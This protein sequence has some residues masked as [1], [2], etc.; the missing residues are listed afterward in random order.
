MKHRLKRLGSAL[1]AL[2]LV[3]PFVPVPGFAASSFETMRPGE[4]LFEGGENGLPRQ[5]VSETAYSLAPGVTEYVTYTN[6]PKGDNQNIDYFCEIDLSQ[7]EIMAGYAGM[8]NI[9]TNHEISWRMQTVSDQVES[10]QSFFRRSE[11]YADATIV[12]ALNADFYNMATGEP[13]GAL[14]IDGVTYHSVNSRYYFGITKD[15]KAVISNSNDTSNLAYA[16]GGSSLLIDNG[17][18]NVNPGGRN[19][20][21][22]AIGIKA[23]GTVV[24]MVCYGQRYPVSCGYTPYEVAQM[25]LARGCV[26]ALQL[27]GS[28]SSTFVSRREGDNGIITRN[29]PSDGQERQ[30]SSSLFI[31]SRVKAD[32]IFDHAALSPANEVY[33]PGSTVQLT[34]AGADQSGAPAPL[35]NDVTWSVDGNYGTIDSATGLFHSNGTEGDVTVYLNS[36]GQ[37]VGETTITIAAPDQLLFSAEQVNIG[38]G[39]TSDLGLLVRYQGRSVNYKDGD[40]IWSLSNDAMGS[41]TGNLFKAS[42]TESLTGTATVTSQW[43]AAVT[44]T[45]NLEVGR[46][47]IIAMDFENPDWKVVHG[48]TKDGLGDVVGVFDETGAYTTDASAVAAAT[49]GADAYCLS[50]TDRNVGQPQVGNAEIVNIADGAPVH[51]GSHSM[52]LDYNFTQNNNQTDG[53]CFGLSDTLVLDG[54]PNK[55][56]LWVYVPEGTPN[57]WLRLRYIDGTGNASQIDFTKGTT[58]GEDELHKL[59]DNAWHYYEADL[60]NLTPP[61]TI[62]AGMCIRLMVLSPQTSNTGWTLADGTKIDKSECYGSL[63]FDDLTFVYGSTNRDVVAPK[64]TEVTVNEEP[65]T[66]GQHFG[67]NVLAFNAYFEDSEADSLFNSGINYNNVLLYVDGK[68]ITDAFIDESAGY[69]RHDNLVL[70]Q[71][72]HTIRLLVTDEAGN[73][74]IR[75]YT[76]VVDA[77]SAPQSPVEV[78]C[79]EDS[80][81]LGKTVTLHFTPT[82]SDVTSIDVTLYINRAYRDAFQLTAG[83]G[84][85]KSK[86]AVYDSITN[87]V[88]FTISRAGAEAG[89]AASLTFSIPSGVVPGTM[90]TARVTK[91]IVT[92]AS[93]HDELPTFGSAPIEIPVTAPYTVS[94][95]VMVAGLESSLVFKVTDTAT[96]KPA[97]GITLYKSD[98]SSIGTVPADGQVSYVPAENETTVTVYAKDASGNVSGSY[99]ATIYRA[100]GNTDGTPTHVWRN[101]SDDTNSF[102]VSWLSNPLYAAS[103]AYLQLSESQDAVESAQLLTG[104]CQLTGFTDGAA[105][106][107]CGVTVEGL[108][109]GTTYYYRVGDGTHWSEIRNFSTGYENTAF[110]ALILGDLQESNNTTL[111]GILNHLDLADYDLAI[112]TGDLVDSGGNYGYWDDTLSMLEKLDMDRLFSLGNHEAEGGLPIATLMYHQ[113][114]QDYYSVE[115]GNVYIASIAHNGGTVGYAAA[116]DWLVKDAAASDATWKILVTHQPAYYTNTEGGSE[117]ANALIPA[118]VQEA[119]IDVVLSGHDHSY[120]RT[121]PLWDGDVNE[122]NGVTYFICGS[123]GEKSYTVTENPNFHFA[124]TSD[125]FNA[126]YL[127]L[128]TTSDTLTINAYDYKDSGTAELLDTFT[129]VKD[130]GVHEH[131]YTWNGTDRLVCDCGY[132]ISSTSYTGYAS[133]TTPA[134]DSGTI[135]LNAG[136]L[137]TGYFAVGEN[138]VHHAGSDGLLHNSETVNTAQCWEDGNLACWCHDCNEFRL[139]SETRRQGHLYDENHICT[140]QV[141]NM[142]TLEYETCG[143]HA[144]SIADMDIK[145]AYQYGY[146][147]GEARKP[148]VTVTDPD[149]GET[150]FAQSTYGDFMPYWENNVNVGTATVRVVGYSD[151]PVYGEAELTFQIVPQNIS[152]D[153]LAVTTTSNSAHL[154]WEAALGATHYIVYQNVNG[155]WTRL[156]I[157]SKPEYTVTGLSSGEYQ[158]RIRPFATV[159]GQNYYSTKN[160]DI[161]TV[162]IEGGGVTFTEN[163]TITRTYGDAP[164]VNAASLDGSDEGFTY[165]SADEQVATVDAATGE[166]TIVGAGSTVVTAVRGELTGQYRLTV[167]P[168][169]VTLTWSGT[170]ERTYDGH[171]SHVAA[172]AG[173]LMEGDTV[174]VTVS[175]GSEKNAGKHTATAVSLDTPNYAL[176]GDCTVEY[177]I[178]PAQITS[179][180]WRNTELT[181]TGQPLAPIPSADSLVEGDTVEFAVPAVTEIGTYTVTAVSKN[182][183]YVV[184]EVVEPCTFVISAPEVTLSASEDTPLT[185]HLE[186]TTIYISGL[187]ETDVTVRVTAVLENGSQSSSATVSAGDQAIVAMGG[188]VYSVDASGLVQ[189]DPAI[190]LIMG[191]TQATLPDNLS[192]EDQETLENAANGENSFGNIL[193]SAASSVDSLV[194][195]AISGL[196]T[197]PDRVSVEI[198]QRLTVLE[199]TAGASYRVEIVPVY[200]VKDD[201]AGTTLVENLPLDNACLAAPVTVT[202]TV[203]DTIVLNQDTY[204][205]HQRSNGQWEYLKPTAISGQAI[206]FVTDSFS[207]F[208]IVSDNRTA[209]VLFPMEDGTL[210]QTYTPADLGISLPNVVAPAEQN[211]DGW[212]IEGTVYTQVTEALLNALNGKEAIAEAVFS[213]NTPVT[214]GGSGG[215]STYPV[216]VKELA[217]GTVKV[218]HTQAAQGTHV[219]LTVTPD[220]SYTISSVTVQDANGNMVKVTGS[221][222]S[223]TF[224]MPASAVTVTVSFVE[225][226]CPSEHFTDIDTS[227]WYHEYLDYVIDNGIMNGVGG[228]YFDPDGSLNRAML[229]TMLWRME[230]E[231]MQLTDIPFTDVPEESWYTAAVRWAYG[232]GIV[233]GM[234]ADTF[235]PAKAITRQQMAAMLYRYAQ[236]KGYDTTQSGMSIREFADYDRIADW[237]LEPMDWAVNAGLMSGRGGN[238]LVPDGEATRAEI[239]KVVMLFRETIAQ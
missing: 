60:S 141:F 154:T 220:A 239:A 89:P 50:Y 103:T 5:F 194:E 150:Y 191:S 125:D 189:K 13:T 120:A 106:N 65:L 18:I 225:T 37:V 143:F 117:N 170:E 54:N 82:N 129:K 48:T 228:N 6:E 221:G 116:L 31:I 53:V 101:A 23:D 58:T 118:A 16:V 177:T 92:Y 193:A 57:L 175:G 235:A 174:T 59:A 168:K 209:T 195:R 142:K 7:A 172:T 46:E 123:L 75:T 203:P 84:W 21:Y 131:N 230:G 113:S 44:A 201:T 74:T 80:A 81:V 107:V 234:T 139:F 73:Q 108:S 200:S 130:G 205:R 8:E 155:T 122:E 11:D 34:A 202:I 30:V 62:P 231:P 208:E 28:G 76:I 213:S 27:D 33:T 215:V 98:G 229:V 69:I 137:M 156:G 128:S 145:L 218:S 151:G 133:Y 166:V 10:A 190:G 77:P 99:T 223:Y 93:A 104:N 183:N 160:S 47:P 36:G 224:T 135:Y 238:M 51:S 148:A 178:L 79:S 124:V 217:H 90:F 87:T 127:T 211:F 176:P 233:D 149:T 26:T 212:K 161:I 49:D 232:A 86:D 4:T 29:N 12:A 119:G 71:G 197:K 52:R 24:S 85:T 97:A 41:F 192:E 15:G 115:Y 63:Y 163:G 110:H 43:D 35:P 64:V 112:Q 1:L 114:N 25:M 227:K 196:E 126:V 171:P 14:I 206:T 153:S 179:L 180:T 198:A 17:E 134:G 83:N 109:P 3:L 173:G 181:Y 219:T 111:S 199:Y 185:W 45:V 162:T 169:E 32:G 144:K 38:F 214:P 222:S 158:F 96:G 184:D 147:T 9:L 105:A 67:T 132:S 91:G 157:V 186:G 216:E 188:V 146:Y 66:D 19:V 226:D 159:D 72:E 94:S 121:E 165:S 20:T 182:P 236:F 61:V 136:K 100:A 207:E 164:F 210:T 22:T 68:Q 187:S 70:S 140:R 152:A 78:T 40:F 39:D 138:T 2:L 56:G 237:A 167:E 102:N 55:I 88:S 95:G 42:E 204:V